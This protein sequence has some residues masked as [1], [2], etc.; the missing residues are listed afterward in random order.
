MRHL[1]ALLLLVIATAA[2]AQTVRVIDGDSLEVAGEDIRL[3]GIDAPEGSQMCQRN[4][5]RGAA[6]TTRKRPSV[7]SW[8]ALRS[9]ATCW[10]ATARAVGL[11][12]CFANALE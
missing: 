3:I 2:S 5:R 7:S 8:T 10:G 6:V 12:V 4:G 1:L 9:A 11:G